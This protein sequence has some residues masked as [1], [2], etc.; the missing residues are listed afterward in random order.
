MRMR[1]A[2]LL[3]AALA[4]IQAG[5]APAEAADAALERS[6]HA[7]FHR[8]IVA[9]GAR[10]E[11][12]RVQRWPDTKGAARWR[13]PTLRGHPAQLF[14]TAI[15]GKGAHARRWYVPVRVRWWAR[16]VVA[17]EDIPARAILD[18]SMLTVAKADVA[19][20]AG[21]WWREPGELAGVRANRPIARGEVVF[22]SA[23]RRPPLVQRGRE[24][25]ILARVGGIRVTALGT[26]LRAANRGEVVPVRNRRSK[27][28]VQAR[29]VD[30]HTVRVVVGGA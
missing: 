8:G 9:D 28:I 25:T 30:A 26:A 1:P 4:I 7:F 27:Q 10:A 13:M 5:A 21:R 18:P 15:Q 6:L 11:L 12:V 3:L 22:S 16:A 14:L 24:V 20:R 29:V 19:G 23:V 2:I 17:R